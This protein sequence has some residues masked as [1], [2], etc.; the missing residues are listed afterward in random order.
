MS[1]GYDTSKGH[2]PVHFKGSSLGGWRNTAGCA[3]LVSVSERKVDVVETAA[4]DEERRLLG[5]V[6]AICATVKTKYK[7]IARAG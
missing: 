6:S 7:V 3:L 4:S 2:I 1:E 5:G